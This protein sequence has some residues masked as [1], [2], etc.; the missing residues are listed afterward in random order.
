MQGDAPDLGAYEFEPQVKLH[1]RSGDQAIYLSWTVNITLP[2]TT[3]WTIIY[4]GPAGDAAFT[5]HR[6]YRAYARLHPN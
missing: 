1:G 5:N 2:T 3:T 4:D 6:S